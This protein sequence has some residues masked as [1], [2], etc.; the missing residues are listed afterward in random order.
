[1]SNE[2][3]EGIVDQ[4]TDK[5]IVLDGTRLS[6]SKWFEGER[7]TEAVLGCRV[8]VVVDAGEKCTFLKKVVEIGEKVPGWNPPAAGPGGPWGGG[9]GRRLSPEELELKRAD[10][11]RIARCCAVERAVDMVERGIAVEMIASHAR[12]LEEYFLTGEIPAPVSKAEK[13]EKPLEV[14]AGRPQSPPP[15]PD[16]VVEVPQKPPSVPPAPTGG[17]P[18]QGKPEAP[19]PPAKP[20]RLESRAVNALFNEARRG[21][22][23]ADWKDYVSLIRMALGVEVQ[24][25]YHLGLEGFAK[26]ESWVRSRLKASKVA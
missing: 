5:G 26:V 18:S 13:R 7:L 3:R 9:G 2:T 16:K 21:G 11:I 25:P 6:Y 22:L 8:K 12:L 20:K 19:K 14:A 17:N 1:M 10:G 23:I 24:D 4:L 15:S